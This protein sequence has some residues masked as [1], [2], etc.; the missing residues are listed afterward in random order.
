[1]T[2]TR[3]ASSDHI[4]PITLRAAWHIEADAT[5]STVLLALPYNSAADVAHVLLNEHDFYALREAFDTAYEHLRY[6]KE[7]P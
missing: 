4:D 5:T 7:I 1:V 2:A 3:V 6:N